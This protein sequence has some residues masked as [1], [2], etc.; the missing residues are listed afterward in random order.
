MLLYDIEQGL[1]QAPQVFVG[2]DLGMVSV[3]DDNQLIGHS[4]TKNVSYI[5]FDDNTNSDLGVKVP[6]KA[7][8]A[9]NHY[10][11]RSRN[12]DFELYYQ[13]GY[14]TSGGELTRTLEYD[15]KGAGG[16][17]TR[18]FKG[19]DTAFLQTTEEDAGLGGAPNGERD[20]SGGGLEVP[21]PDKR[22]RYANA[23][24][25][26]DFYELQVTYEQEVLGAAWRVVAHGPDA[27]VND[28]GNND[29]IQ[30]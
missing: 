19:T 20:L 28:N 15:Y 26:K 17:E 5:L 11:E 16:T 29:I 18:T 10:G 8:F 4:Y 3:S 14:I 23:F 6:T 25:S 21:T 1:W 2:I 7:K 9:Y 27:E 24:P 12:K 30:E 22:F 13:D